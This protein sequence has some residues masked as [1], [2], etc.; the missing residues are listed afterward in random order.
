[1]KEDIHRG[2]SFLGFVRPC[3]VIEPCVEKSP[4]PQFLPLADLDT[5]QDPGEHGGVARVRP[6][7]TPLGLSQRPPSS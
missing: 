1:M 2:L 6:R 4:K 3:S 7:G 5:S